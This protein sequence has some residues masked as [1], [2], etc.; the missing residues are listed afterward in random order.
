[1]WFWR[2]C[3]VPD[4][5]DG[6]QVLSGAP[7][8]KASSKPWQRRK[9]H[10]LRENVQC[11]GRRSSNSWIPAR[12]TPWVETHFWG[13]KRSVN[14][15]LCGHGWCKEHMGGVGWGGVLTTCTPREDTRLEVGSVCEL[16]Q[17]WFEWWRRRT[18]SWP[19]P[20]VSCFAL[21]VMHSP[22]R[23]IQCLRRSLE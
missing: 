22:S 5:N 19:L 1:M 7:S 18:C 21:L 13:S 8:C 11:E 9:G 4:V 20:C 23:T 15:R 14:A 12:R 6:E 17:F 3:L 2:S 16:A 10:C